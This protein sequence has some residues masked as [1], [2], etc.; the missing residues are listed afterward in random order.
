M[1]IITNIFKEYMSLKYLHKGINSFVISW[2]CLWNILSHI[3]LMLLAL[4][5]GQSTQK[6]D[7]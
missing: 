3:T 5:N 1:E 2:C 6:N 7:L 4:L